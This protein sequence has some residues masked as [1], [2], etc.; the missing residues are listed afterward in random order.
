MGHTGLWVPRTFQVSETCLWPRNLKITSRG[1]SDQK[2]LSICFRCAGEHNILTQPVC[3]IVNILL[4][5]RPVLGLSLLLSQT[6]YEFVWIILVY[7]DWVWLFM[8][9]FCGSISICFIQVPVIF[10]QVSFRLTTTQH[11][12]PPTPTHRSDS[13]MQWRI[14]WKQRRLQLLLLKLSV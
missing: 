14:G 10:L 12:H 11:Q 9:P 6:H 2:V 1:C 4:P 7:L 8:V 5:K 13:G 3:H